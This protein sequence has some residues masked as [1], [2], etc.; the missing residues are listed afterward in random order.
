M[1]VNFRAH[2]RYSENS[3]E[4]PGEIAY[5]LADGYGL[6]MDCADDSGGFY[7]E[8]P[9][10][11]R[12]HLNS[13]LSTGR[14]TSLLDVG[15]LFRVGFRLSPA[16]SPL[17]SPRPTHKESTGNAP[18]IGVNS[19]P[20]DAETTHVAAADIMAIHNHTPRKISSPAVF[21]SLSKKEKKGEYPL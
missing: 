15:R 14:K 9:L 6:D 17:H 8:V 3:L 21:R 1:S 4:V 11:P 18:L 2:N 19:L 7:L 12:P 5:I 16:A 10:S 20:V 13:T